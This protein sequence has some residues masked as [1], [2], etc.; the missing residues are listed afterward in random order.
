MHWA[1]TGSTAWCVQECLHGPWPMAAASWDCSSQQLTASSTTSSTRMACPTH[2]AACW[3]VGSAWRGWGQHMVELCHMTAGRLQHD[4]TE[5]SHNQQQ[6]GSQKHMVS[7]YCRSQRSW[8][9]GLAVRQSAV[10]QHMPYLVSCLLRRRFAAQVP[11]PEPSTALPAALARPSSPRALVLW[12]A[13]R[14]LQPGRC[15]L[16][17]KRAGTQ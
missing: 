12:L 3:Q 9:Q 17:C 1:L 10:S 16:L 4:C 6:A 8:S 11:R 5:H 13:P 2:S 15:S 14:W 7:I